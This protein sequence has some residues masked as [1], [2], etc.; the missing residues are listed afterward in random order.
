MIRQYRQETGKQDVD[1]HDV[2]K[3]ARARGWKMPTPP[4]AIDMLAKEFSTAARE[5]IRY[6]NTTKRPYRANHCFMVTS[7]GKQM[8]LWLDIDGQAPRNKMVMS[9]A[10]RR[11]QMI[12]DGLQLAL[13]VEHWNNIN[14]SDEPI[15]LDLDLTDEVEWRKNAPSADED[16]KAS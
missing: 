15:Q 3:F 10:T 4:D 8:H 2:A 14:P 6:D 9:I 13:D 7:G 5:E 11:E 16:K 1:M 12:G